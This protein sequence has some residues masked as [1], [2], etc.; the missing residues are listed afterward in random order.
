M[1]SRTFE[2][3]SRPPLSR[4]YPRGFAS[5]VA[6]PTSRFCPSMSLNSIGSIDSFAPDHSGIRPAHCTGSELVVLVFEQDVERGERSGGR[7]VNRNSW[8][9]NRCGGCLKLH[10]RFL[11]E[12]LERDR[13]KGVRRGRRTRHAGRVCS[14]MY[15]SS[16]LRF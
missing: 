16:A 10:F 15:S 8:I 14:P 12:S 1:C 6:F 11:E 13:R 9:V 2:T 4:R 7:C 5:Y 3:R